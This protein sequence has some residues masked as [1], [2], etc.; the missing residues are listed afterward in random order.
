MAPLFILMTAALAENKTQGHP[1]VEPVSTLA[2]TQSNVI[3]QSTA[4]ASKTGASSK[5]DKEL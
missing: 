5:H 3:Y 4:L 2:T 1:K